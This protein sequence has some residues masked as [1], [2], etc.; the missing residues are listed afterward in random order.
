[1]IAGSKGKL[2]TPMLFSDTTNTNLFNQWL[3]EGLLTKFI[4]AF[5]SVDEHL[6]TLVGPALSGPT[7]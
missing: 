5:L 4:V 7:G 6:G 3:Q 1:M 2:T